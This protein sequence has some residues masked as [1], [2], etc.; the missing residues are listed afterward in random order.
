MTG[1]RAG[2]V[3]IGIAICLVALA[4]LGLAVPLQAFLLLAFGWVHFLWRVVPDVKT[5][6]AG[7]ATG[8]IALALLVVGLHG[9]LRWLHAG[10]GALRSE[11]VGMDTLSESVAVW[12][13]RWT[14]SLV[15]IVLMIFVAGISMV[16]IAHQLAWLANSPE[17][18]VGSGGW[19]AARR[20][21]S[22][23]NLRNMTIAIHNYHD[24]QHTFPGT[25]TDEGGQELSGWQTTILAEYDSQHFKEIDL[26]QRWD[27]PQNASAYKRKVPAFLIPSPG[28]PKENAAGYALSHYAANVHVLGGKQRLRMSQITDGTSNTILIGE[29]A[30]NYRPWGHP[31]NY[32]DPTLGINKS[33]DG[34]GSPWPA[35]AVFS[36]ADGSTRFLTDDIDPQVL[37]ALATPR[38]GEK[39]GEY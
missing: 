16:G 22:S 32:R 37:R 1:A 23:S 11:P 6:T 30:G 29:A 19:L 27:S 9:F 34:F 15:I 20:M 10:I 13:L 36:F 3:A 21:S 39:V 4:C 18:L 31:H 28:L 38:G 8:V 5:D 33:P 2:R 7:A 17:P 35:G 25:M 26:T 24:A 12:R 14:T